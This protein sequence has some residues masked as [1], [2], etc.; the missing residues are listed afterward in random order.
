M[1]KFKW[2]IFWGVFATLTFLTFLVIRL[3]IFQKK[4]TAVAT[5]S[6]K[7]IQRPADTW[8]N[9]YQ[10]SKKI[11]VV[12]R[13]FSQLEKGSHS[14]E[15]VFM[16]INTMGVTQ[17]L[18]I[19]TETDL[20][21]DQTLSSFNFDL[22]S[23]LFRFSAHGFVV[24][25]KL[26]LY[27]GLP[28]AQQKSE[29]PL[30]EIPYMSGSI[31]DASFHANMTKEETQNFR[32]FDPSTMGMR[33][34]KVTRNADEVIPVMGK[35]IL[36]QKYCADIMGAKNCAWLGKDGDVLKETGILGLTMEKVTAQKAQEGISKEG[37][38]DLTEIA[39]IPTNIK[40]NE[41]DKLSKI[42]IRISG[43]KERELNLNSDRQSF[44]NGVLTITKEHLS[45][46][47]DAGNLSPKGVLTYL[48]ATPL[49]QANHPA[50]KAQVAKI[51]K[52]GDSQERKTGR[53]IN[54]VY[55]SVEKKPVLSIPNA[56]E[57]LQNKVG[58]CNEH[59][60]LLA[61][62]LRT[63][64]IP[65]Q[66]ETG[67]VYLRG[68]FYYHAWNVAYINGKWI[69]ADAVFNQFPSDVTH[70]RLVRGEG[71]EQLDLMGV[72]G[73]IKLDILEQIK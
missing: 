33:Q 23:S 46:T 50:M 71:S 53:I 11:G 8:M 9:I 3:D 38:I 14:S 67:L 1:K 31:Y 5:I 61:A 36:T 6:S 57:V 2:N 68:R 69:T 64:G 70:L 45:G 49:V 55:T 25:D 66:I 10:N 15:T 30:K 17:A 63:A 56:L 39:S 22:H 19:L 62:L 65:A 12:H 21:P 29:I 4:T 60:V 37:S 72:M 54:W 18:N 51:I 13:T 27:T 73:K 35:R 26:I 48:Q 41:P 43:I 44:K 24:K 47:Q 40:I 32:I 34:V 16:Q 20:N 52:P 58:D 28:D 42:Q 7:T 59:A